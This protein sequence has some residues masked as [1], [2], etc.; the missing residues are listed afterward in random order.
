MWKFDNI[1]TGLTGPKPQY[2]AIKDYIEEKNINIIISKGKCVNQRNSDLA[3]GELDTLLTEF[4]KCDVSMINWPGKRPS[5]PF[6]AADI[7]PDTRTAR[8]MFLLDLTQEAEDGQASLF[9][10][11][12]M[13][14]LATQFLAAR[15]D[16]D[17]IWFPFF[18]Q[19]T[20][21]RGVI[22]QDMDQ[23]TALSRP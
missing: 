10:S 2:Q 5:P 7:D 19:D 12:L 11:K 14:A 21:G 15:Q 23:G 18:L 4:A 3:P 22:R 20:V 8:V 16:V 1:K 17:K 13:G 9:Y 6:L